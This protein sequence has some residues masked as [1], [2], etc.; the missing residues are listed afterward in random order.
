[1]MARLFQICCL[2]LALGMPVASEVIGDNDLVVIVNADSGIA[3]LSRNDLI[4]LY[5][6]RIH[7]LPSG[8]SVLPLDLAQERSEF[9]RILVD[10]H[11]AEINSYWARLVFSGRASPPRQVAST[12]EILDIVASNRGAIGYLRR[13]DVDDRVLVLGSLQ[14]L[15]P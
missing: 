15:R 1:M 10:K 8:G 9:Y 12:G 7:R 13:S 6:G 4:N 14:E 5:M 2:V 3:L 11:L